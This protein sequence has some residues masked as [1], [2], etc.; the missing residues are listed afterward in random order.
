M[1]VDEHFLHIVKYLLSGLKTVL[2]SGHAAE[3]AR[4]YSR[5]R[6]ENPFMS[7]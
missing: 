1:H 7:G 4:I 3:K 5:F 6:G 2:R